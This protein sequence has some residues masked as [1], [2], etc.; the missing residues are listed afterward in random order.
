MTGL[1]SNSALMSGGLSAYGTTTVTNRIPDASDLETRYVALC[2]RVCVLAGKIPLCLFDAT[3][4]N[5]N[6]IEAFL[7]GRGWSL[8][9]R[10]KYSVFGEK[11]TINT[12]KV[13]GQYRREICQGRSLLQFSSGGLQSGRFQFSVLPKTSEIGTIPP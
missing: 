8:A 10:Q 1:P 13:N 3:W 12:L 11:V 4:G 9:N 2:G 7:M 6:E 5:V